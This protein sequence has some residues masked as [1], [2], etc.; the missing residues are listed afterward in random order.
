MLLPL[1]AEAVLTIRNVVKVNHKSIIMAAVLAATL[2]SLSQAEESARQHIDGNSAVG[3]LRTYVEQS[4]FG[5]DKSTHVAVANVAGTKFAVAYLQG[6]TWCG[7]GGCTLLVL[8]SMGS[9]YEVIG[10]VTTVSAPIV[11]LGMKNSG[12]PEIGVWVQGGGI[13]K[14]YEAALSAKGGKYPA[15]PSISGR[16][17]PTGRGAV[18]IGRDDRGIALFE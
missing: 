11:F 18:L 7:S 12:F 14:G 5:A 13:Q 17:V 3:F 9:S 8:K 6:N 10:K 1:S 4:R 16:R 15:S 2:P